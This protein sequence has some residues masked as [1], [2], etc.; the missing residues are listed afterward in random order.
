MLILTLTPNIFL[1]YSTHLYFYF[2][3]MN[4]ITIFLNLLNYV[5]LIKGKMR[6]AGS[7]LQP[8]FEW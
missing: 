2:G 3:A 8:G 4:C 5:V 6:L 7:Y 1:F